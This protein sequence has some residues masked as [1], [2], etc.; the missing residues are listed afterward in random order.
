MVG[1]YANCLPQNITR[2][3]W[4]QTDMSQFEQHPKLHITAA[5]AGLNML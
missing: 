2:R 4:V 3:F 1:N 5:P